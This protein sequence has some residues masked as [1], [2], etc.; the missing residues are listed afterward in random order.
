MDLAEY[1]AAVTGQIRC[2]RA[3]AMVAK[4]LTGHIEDQEAAYLSEGGSREEARKDAVL[5]MGDAVEVGM[6]LDRIHR[7]IMD[8]KVLF[9]VV[10]LSI[11]GALIQYM[12]RSMVSAEQGRFAS[13]L[14]GMTELLTAGAG[15]IIMWSVLFLDYTALG[16]YPIPVW[17]ILTVITP[18][19]NT[20]LPRADTYI[21]GTVKIL[22]L[23]VTIPCFCGVVCRYRGK[24]GMGILYS[25]F[26]LMLW[27]VPTAITTSYP[28]M[29]R[30]YVWV[31]FFCCTLIIAFCSLRG[32]YGGSRR[33]QLVI[34]LAIVLAGLAGIVFYGQ[35]SSGVVFDRIAAFYNPEEYATGEGYLTLCLRERLGQIA[36][37][38]QGENQALLTGDGSLTFVTLLNRYGMLAGILLLGVFLLLFGGMIS[39]IKK[40]KN[41]LGGLVG[42]GCLMGLLVPCLLHIMVNLSFVPLTDI[43]MPFCYPGFAVNVGCYVLMGF[44]LSVYRNTNVVA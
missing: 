1:I 38:G 14:P 43:F 41:V 22:L 23:G 28:G 4:E 15:L 20:V 26:W 34:M 2:K 18:A 5:Q 13:L 8:K 3:R 32:W 25:L 19:L 39:G 24:G 16:K 35:M 33:R 30:M 37:M 11:A 40:Q 27:A 36:L 42:F 17:M 6:E 31:T 12:M 10:V 7:P 9:I 21:A 29:R 44:Y